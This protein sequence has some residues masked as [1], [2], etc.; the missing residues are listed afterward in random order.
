MLAFVGLGLGSEGTSL[1]GLRWAQSAD[2]V[3]AELYT[4]LMPGLDLKQLEDVVYSGTSGVNVIPPGIMLEG[5]SEGNTE[6]IMALFKDFP[7]KSDYLVL[8]MPP[9]REAV[10][11]LSEK[12][13]ALLVVNPDKASILDALNMKMLLSG[14]DVNI[15]GII[16]NRAQRNDEKWIDEIE[17]V[18]ES[19]VVAVIPESMVVKEALHSEECFVKVKP[20]S[21]PSKE[22]MNLA[23]ELEIGNNLIYED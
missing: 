21:K 6:K 17:R 23:K 5:Y 22:I 15:L 19:N 4:S 3:Y 9:G 8:D 2:E 16:L 18:L 14:K 1:G 13:E 12:M 7:I 10:N 11:V 20:E